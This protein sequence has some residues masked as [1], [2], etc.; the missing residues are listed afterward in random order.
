MVEKTDS[1]QKPFEG[2]I[3]EETRRHFKAARQEFRKSMEGILPPGF[4]EHRDNARREMMLAF[5]S[6]IDA[7]LERME[8]ETK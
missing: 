7:S 5:R 2:K 6:M 3:P 1:K 8:K 4:K